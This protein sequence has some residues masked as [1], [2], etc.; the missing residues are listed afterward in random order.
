MK[1]CEMRLDTIIQIELDL[2]T[3]RKKIEAVMEKSTQI[4][5]LCNARLRRLEVRQPVAEAK[6][7]TVVDNPSSLSSSSDQKL[8]PR[9]PQDSTAA[10]ISLSD[11][12]RD[13]MRHITENQENKIRYILECVR[14]RLQYEQYV[15]VSSH[16]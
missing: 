2:K 12:K 16:Y 10:V 5:C 8:S 13:L 15:V 7:W 4:V 1:S 9:W 14:Q 3:S 6:P 11:S